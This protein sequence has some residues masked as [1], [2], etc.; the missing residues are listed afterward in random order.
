[1]QRNYLFSRYNLIARILRKMNNDSIHS[2]NKLSLFDLNLVSHKLA[3][4][5]HSRSNS[6]REIFFEEKYSRVYII[7]LEPR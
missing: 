4:F 6:C 7:S 5:P 3:I 2:A 1:M